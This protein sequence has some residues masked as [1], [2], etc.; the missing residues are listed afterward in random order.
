MLARFSPACVNDMSALS[1]ANWTQAL[2]LAP[3]SQ[4]EDDRI[5]LGVLGVHSFLGKHA[6]RAAIRQTWLTSVPDDIVAKFAMRS[7][8]SEGKGTRLEAVAHGDIVLLNAPAALQRSAGPVRSTMLWFACAIRTWPS[9]R[10]VGHAEDDVYVHLAGSA[11]HLR[12]SL[13]QLPAPSGE[14]LPLIYWG[15]FKCFHWS[16]RLHAAVPGVLPDRTMSNFA[17]SRQ[18][19]GLYTNSRCR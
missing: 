1:S 3:C 12:A 19:L 2:D 5:L 18:I 11:R 4:P 16:R 9:A 10:L 14:S 7:E 13:E 17:R 15:H 8:G 6:L